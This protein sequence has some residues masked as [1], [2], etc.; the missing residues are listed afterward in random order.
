MFSGIQ[1]PGSIH[2]GN[3]LGAIR[4]WVTT[5]ARFENIFCIVDLHALTTPRGP[6]VL[7][8]RFARSQLYY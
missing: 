7:S 2:I 1:P 4:H 6:E 3:Y 5:Q 8:P